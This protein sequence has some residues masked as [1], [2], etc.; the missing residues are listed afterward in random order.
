MRGL[1]PR[2]GGPGVERGVARRIVEHRFAQA[3]QALLVRQV[4]AERHRRARGAARRAAARRGALRARRAS[5]VERRRARRRARHRARAPGR[6]AGATPRARGTGA[7]ALDRPPWPPARSA[8]AAGVDVERQQLGVLDHRDRVLDARRD[9]ERA[10]RRH[11]VGAVRHRDPDH[12]GASRSRSAPTGG[13][14]ARRG[15]RRSRCCSLA[16]TGRARSGRNRCGVSGPTGGR[17]AVI[18]GISTEVDPYRNPDAARRA[19]HAPL[20]TRRAMSVRCRA[21]LADSRRLR[22]APRRRR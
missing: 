9:P 10:R 20:R 22:S 8:R 2:V 6:A 13:R 12:A 11:D 3:A 21:T 19:T 4:D 5:R 14:A 7:S 16:R 15:C 1:A 18:G 17:E